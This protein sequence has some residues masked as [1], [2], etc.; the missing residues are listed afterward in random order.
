MNSEI[1]N[2][3]AGV[4][5]EDSITKVEYHT[6]SPFL[7]SFKNNDEV[8]ICVQ[9]Q[10]L[11]MLPSSSYIYIEG[12]LEKT[13]ATI[14]S[15]AKLVNNCVAHLFDEIRYELNGI[16]IDRIRNVGISSTLKNYISLNE[17]ESKM[18]LNAAWCPEN[19]IDISTGNFN[20][21]KH[22][23]ILIRARN[24]N[25]AIISATDSV[26]FNITKLQWRVAHIQI[27]DEHKLALYKFI[28]GGR[29]IQKSFRNWNMYEYPVLPTTTHHIR[30]VKTSSQLEKPRYVIF[31]FQNN[32]RNDKTKNASEF[33]H[34]NLSDIK[35]YLNS[36]SFPYD[37]LN[38]DFNKNK[39]ALLYD[40]YAR[41]QQSYYATQ[42]QPLLTPKEFK[43]RAPIIVLDC[44][45]Q[46][47][48]IKTG[49]VDLKIE[50][51]TASNISSNT[52][53]YC[54]I[55]HDR[56]IDYNPLTNEVKKL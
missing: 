15:T 14:S 10:D 5:F 36:E 16:E 40:M 52:T 28:N 29:S 17:N 9:H 13:D 51:K 21:S 3:T 43:N 56:I 6:Y 45:F 8:R 25:D 4:Q 48:D 49:P 44:S 39:F 18:L 30:T 53:A 42:N 37:D 19:N 50:F 46:V 38:I 2:I 35:V 41:F 32:R 23:L 12:R 20:F 24:D 47:E 7:S 33:D 54:L 34:G 55:L 26:N 27:Q 31:A 11:N 22:E 1:L